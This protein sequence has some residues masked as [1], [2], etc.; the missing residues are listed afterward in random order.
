MHPAVESIGVSLSRQR[1]TQ[2][3]IGKRIEMKPAEGRQRV[4]IEEIQP[5]VDCGRYPARRFL[6]DRVQVSAAIFSDGH[7]HVLARL[8]YKHHSDLDWRSTPMTALPNDLWEA[9]FTADRIGPWRFTIQAWV[10]HFDTW[11]SDLKQRLDAQP[12]PSSADPIRRNLPPQDIPVAFTIGALLLD[13]TSAR[14]KESDAK[15]LKACAATLRRLASKNSALYEYPLTPEIEALAACYP[16]LSFATTAAR[17][18]HLWVDRERARF[19]SWYELFPR[20]TA[21]AARGDQPDPARHGTFADV[22]LLLPEIAAMGFDI[23]YLPPIHPIGRAYRKGPNNRTIAAVT[24]EGSPWAI[25][26]TEGGH[27]SILYKLGTP[28]DFT[29]LVDAVHA[30]GM[31]LALD[32]AFQC[33][34]DHP[35]VTQH[36]DWFIHRPDGSIQYAENPPKKYQDIYPLNFESSDWLGLWDELRSVFQ[37]W[38][39]CGV[40]VFRVDNP[41]TKALPFWEWCIDDLHRN[42]PDVLFL[43]EAFTRP[44]VMYALAKSGFTQ[45]YTYFTWRTQKDE[46]QAYFEEITKPPISDFFTPNVWPNTP[47]ILHASLQTGGRAAFQQR[48]ILATTLAASYGIY[49]PAYELCEHVPIREGSEE[50]LN[51]EKYQIRQ[52][53]RRDPN[54]LAPLI[55]LLNQ[56]RRTNPALQSDL[57]LHFHPVDNPQIIAYSKSAPVAST[58]D[59]IAST[60]KPASDAVTEGNEASSVTVGKTAVAMSSATEASASAPAPTTQPANVILTVVNLDPHNEQSGWIDLDLKRLGIAH[61]ETFDVED[62][63]TGIHY[64]WHD[65]SNYVALHPTTTAHIFRVTHPKA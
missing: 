47:D 54:S 55:T 2:S 6:G 1:K 37:F 50:Y 56:I 12:D 8:L 21:P 4:L 26:A 23:L 59:P 28:A 19:S 35:W 45:S 57:S 39:D 7:D 22:E 38:I 15:Q 27:K 32:I 65:R 40:R 33:S 44:H 29:H 16:D 17:E 41:H 36:P 48:L 60:S 14:A 42:A 18:L 10:D 34:P 25:G 53:N 64:Q 3:A 5:Q 43:A 62:L 30:S 13:Q 58:L 20:S 63:L 51:S 9:S 24:D 31:E 11:C 52:W 46:L 49:G 61:N